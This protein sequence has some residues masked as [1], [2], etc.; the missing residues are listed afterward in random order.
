MPL[1]NQTHLV[2]WLIS[3]RCISK[4]NRLLNDEFIWWSVLASS[5]CTY[6]QINSYFIDSHHY[7]IINFSYVHYGLWFWVC[8]WW[9]WWLLDQPNNKLYSGIHDSNE[10]NHKNQYCHSFIPKIRICLFRYSI[11][12]LFLEY[13]ILHVTL[14]RKWIRSFFSFSWVK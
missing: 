1:L 13:R 9:R 8:W 4:W 11:L 12:V 2:N 3:S 10:A 6:L 5:E 14:E 7:L